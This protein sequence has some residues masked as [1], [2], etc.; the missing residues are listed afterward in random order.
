MSTI[1]DWLAGIL[2]T[3]TPVT[4]QTTRIVEGVEVVEDVVAQG[5]AG[6]D[7]QYIIC[8]LLLL[9]TIYSTFRLLGILLQSIGGRR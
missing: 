6:V 9:V 1:L 3:Y 2:G 8:G 4:Y 7:W 5:S